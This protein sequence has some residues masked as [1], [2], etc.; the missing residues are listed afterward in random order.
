M[1]QE[2]EEKEKKGKIKKEKQKEMEERE[3]IGIGWKRAK[4]GRKEDKRMREKK[5]KA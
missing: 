1:C 5:I 4:N 2:G 3:I